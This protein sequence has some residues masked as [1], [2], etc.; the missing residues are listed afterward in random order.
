MTL[1]G[2]KKFSSSS[3][4][5][6]NF[7]ICNNIT[8]LNPEVFAPI[9]TRSESKILSVIYYFEPT[10]HEMIIGIHSLHNA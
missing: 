6:I 9:K 1:A 8:E 3:L 4:T 2:Q 5:N 7:I 10:Q